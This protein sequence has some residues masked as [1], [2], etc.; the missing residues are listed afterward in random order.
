MTKVDQ[1]TD[2]RTENESTRPVHSVAVKTGWVRRKEHKMFRDNIPYQSKQVSIRHETLTKREEVK[3]AWT[4]NGLFFLL[5]A[6]AGI[7]EGI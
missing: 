1:A 6:L 2:N 7:I 4:F 3:K 5:L